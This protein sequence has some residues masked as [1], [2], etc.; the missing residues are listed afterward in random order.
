MAPRASFLR[1]LAAIALDWF[2]SILVAVLLG[3]WLIDGVRYGSAESSLLTLG[4]FFAEVSLFTALLGGSFGQIALGIRV[5]RVDGGRLGALRCVAR[6][7]L[8]C[9]VIPA[10]VYDAEGR[11]LHDRIVGS[12]VIRLVSAAG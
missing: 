11:G 4:I 9:L 6:T 3:G 10:V 12:R 2:A 7:A 8:L 1:R 5:V